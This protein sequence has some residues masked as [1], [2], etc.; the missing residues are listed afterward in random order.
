MRFL[1]Y[2]IFCK[3]SRVDNLSSISVFWV[4]SQKEFFTTTDWTAQIKELSNKGGFET[5]LKLKH[6]LLANGTVLLKELFHP[7][8]QMNGYHNVYD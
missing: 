8:F 7:F 5:I 4:S 1:F 3:S 2:Q 6:S